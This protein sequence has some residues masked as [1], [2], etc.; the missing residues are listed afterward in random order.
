MFQVSIFLYCGRESVLTKI[1]TKLLCRR[2]TNFAC[3]ESKETQENLF[4]A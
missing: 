3:Y 1:L 2:C 4:V